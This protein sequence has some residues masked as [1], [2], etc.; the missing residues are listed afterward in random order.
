MFWWLFL[1]VLVVLFGYLLREFA[2][3]ADEIEDDTAH[4]Y[5]HRIR[6]SYGSKFL[7]ILRGR[8]DD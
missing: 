5:D 8:G 4:V 7:N 2:K 1:V 3:H 6:S